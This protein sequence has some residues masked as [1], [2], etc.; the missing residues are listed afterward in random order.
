M[1]GLPLTIDVTPEATV[2]DVKAAVANNFS[3]V[4][5]CYWLE[6][7]R[8]GM[9]RQPG[10]CFTTVS[11]PFLVC[12]LSIRNQFTDHLSFFPFISFPL[13]HHS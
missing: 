12:L 3:K 5:T 10:G 2:G 1:R 6:R 8:E 11:P 4:Y 13:L 9:M 7:D